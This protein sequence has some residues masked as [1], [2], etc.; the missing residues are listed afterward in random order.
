MS[1]TPRKSRHLLTLAIQITLS[2]LSVGEMLSNQNFEHESAVKEYA[3]EQGIQITIAFEEIS[4]V[5]LFR[6]P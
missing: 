1:S 3:R 6:H 5:Q 2:D 4:G